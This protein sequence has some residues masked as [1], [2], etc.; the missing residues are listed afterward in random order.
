MANGALKQCDMRDPRIIELGLRASPRN[1][2]GETDLHRTSYRVL[3]YAVMSAIHVTAYRLLNYSSNSS[4]TISSI[5]S[6]LSFRHIHSTHSLI[7]FTPT[8]LVAL[9][10]TALSVMA[11]PAP[12]VGTAAVYTG[13]GV[14]SPPHSCIYLTWGYSR[15]ILCHRPWRL[16]YFQQ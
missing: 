16:R 2:L 14:W 7:M 11:L 8:K 13:E 3:Q 12:E 15:N 9:L 4:P 6:P 5:L 1:A 10:A